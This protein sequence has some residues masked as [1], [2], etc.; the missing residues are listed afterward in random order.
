MLERRI[1]TCWSTGAGRYF[2]AA[3]SLILG[4]ARSAYE[5][6]L[7]MELEAL[8]RSALSAGE[9]LPPWPVSLR[10][11]PSSPAEA[12]A[13]P[14]R[15]RID[16]AEAFGAILEERSRGAGRASGAGRRADRPLLAA[17]F[18]RTMAEAIACGVRRLV[19]ETGVRTIALGGGVF[20]NA[21]LLEMLLDLGVQEGWKI[22]LP[23]DLPPNDGGLSYGQLAVVSWDERR[24]S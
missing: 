12:P 14:A 21:V 6:Q 18:H 19:E 2:D 13:W 20:Q 8:A 9:A 22:L 15:F 3:G 1:Q 5:G 11:R 16:L 24:E 17:R 23:R 10:E 7:P 4:R